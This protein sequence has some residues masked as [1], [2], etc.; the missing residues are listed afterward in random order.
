MKKDKD[1]TKLFSD[2][3]NSPSRK[4]FI[5]KTDG[6]YEVFE[7]ETGV[8]KATLFSVVNPIWLSNDIVSFK[9]DSGI[10][11]INLSSGLQEDVSVGD[12]LFG[13]IFKN[14][15]RI[16]VTDNYLV[17]TQQTANGTNIEIVKNDVLPKNSKTYKLE[18]DS[19][20]PDLS[21]THRGRNSIV[22]GDGKIYW[23]IN[24]SSN[25]V[26]CS[27]LQGTDAKLLY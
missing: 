3:S 16:N 25:E 22:I 18:L 8:R 5:K 20:S 23:I 10:K 9:N 2:I 26:F 19:T 7:K 13:R 4:R 6:Y 17:L 14:G 15:W 12:L 24:P 27:I 1:G 21:V 11:I